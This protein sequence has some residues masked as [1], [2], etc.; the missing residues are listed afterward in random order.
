MTES[1]PMFPLN[2]VLF[3]GVSVPLRVFEDRYRALVH[4]LL[5]TEDPAERLFG[6]VAI[7]EG[8]EV[9]EHGAQSLHRVGCRLQMTEIAPH[10]DGSFDVVAVGR[11]RIRLDRLDTSG[12]CPTGEVTVLT[13]DRTGVPDEVTETARAVFTGY[14][15]MVAEIRGVDPHPGSLPTD[16]EYLAWTLAAVAPIPL[17]DQQAVLEAAGPGERLILLTDLFRRELSAMNVIPSL[18]ATRVARTG[19]SPN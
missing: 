8:Y 16:A 14:A 9:G 12:P 6:S 1:L 3:P 15:A 7:R 11:D 5:R 13:E 18:P 17:P 4:R 10:P 2:T 19:W